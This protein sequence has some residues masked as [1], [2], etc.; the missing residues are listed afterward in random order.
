LYEVFSECPGIVPLPFLPHQ[1]VAEGLFQARFFQQGAVREDVRNGSVCQDG[2]VFH[3]DAALTNNHFFLAMATMEVILATKIEGLGAE[4]DLV[5]VKAGYGRNY[6]IPKGLAHEA[7]ASNRRFIANLQAA[8][9]KREA[10]ELSAAQEV[11]AKIS[12]LT[13]DLTLEVGQGGKAFGAITNQN[14]HDALTAQGVEVDRRAIELE[15]PIKSE[16]EHEVV[17]KVHPQVEATLKVVVKEN[18]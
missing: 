12:G 11:A 9:A 1:E 18:A 4:A 16:G 8:R 15:K 5:T 6:L 7:T 13:V 14:I 3:H 17:I 2:A 10:E